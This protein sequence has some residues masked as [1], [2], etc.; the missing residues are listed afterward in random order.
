[1]A[2]CGVGICV[3]PIHIAEWPKCTGG[4]EVRRW[5]RECQ[6]C[7]SRKAN[8]REAIPP[9]RSLR[10]GAV[11]DRWTLDVAGPFPFADG[12]ELYD[13]AVVEYVTRCA[14]ACCVTQHTAESVATFLM[15]EVVLRFGTFRELL[16]E[17][18][19]EMTGKVIEELIT[20]LQAQ[21]VNP[22]PYRPEVVGLVERFHRTWNDCVTTFMQ[23]ERQND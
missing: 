14:V 9:L 16:T 15:Q 12:G 7:G 23:D 11:C 21:Q 8:P 1:M 3:D 2:A 5:V 6:E 13:V 20:L 18:A 17:G 22:V 4:Q 19:P 10:G